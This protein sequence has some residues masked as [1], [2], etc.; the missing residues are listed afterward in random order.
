MAKNLFI[1]GISGCVGHYLFD[2]VSKDPEYNLFL[3]VRD[4][5]RLRFDP[6][7]YKNVT[8]IK[9]ELQDSAKY[10]DLL[11]EMDMVVHLAAGWGM[12]EPNYEYTI[13][14]LKRLDPSRCKKIIYFSTASILGPDNKVLDKVEQ[15]GT[16]YIRGKYLCHK[17]LPSLPVYDRIIT[18]FPTWVLGGDKEHP[19]S[20]AMEGLRDIKKWLWLIRFIS[21]D[22]S[23]HF[24]H[25]RD[26]AI[27]ADHLLK[28]DLKER[29]YILG[30]R[31][32]TADHLI[33]EVCRYYKVRKY[34]KVRLSSKLIK[35]IAALF[36]QKLSDWDSYC[37]DQRKFVYKVSSP[38]TFGLRSD[39]T[40]IPDILKSIN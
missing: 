32:T 11:K 19:Y 4:P 30:N 28:N 10:S 8:L 22:F 2:L 12:S 36:G 5:S 9:A 17:A 21:Y 16:S 6:S 3:L 35:G 20:H 34:F 7:K 27:I 25:A 24:I 38:E 33:D 18:L 23:F 1:T 15:I 26:I 14:L 29:E 13:E 37:L 39:L 40:T 31:S